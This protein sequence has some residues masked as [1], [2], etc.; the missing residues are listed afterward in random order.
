MNLVENIISRLLEN[1]Q[2][3]ADE[4]RD[5]IFKQMAGFS[6]EER[7][8]VATADQTQDRIFKHIFGVSE[9]KPEPG[10]SEEEEEEWFSLDSAYRK[11]REKQEY[12]DQ[13]KK[14]RK[15]ER[16]ENSLADKK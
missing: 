5:R 13:L 10:V 12:L 16:Q 4:E 8:E 6:D 15:E 14:Q 7:E 2:K 11:S 9:P 3:A 1:W